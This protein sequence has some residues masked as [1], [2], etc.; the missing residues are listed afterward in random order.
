[1]ACG[2]PVIAARTGG[3]LD[4]VVDGVNGFYYDPARPEAI[5]LLVSRLRNDPELRANLAKGALHHAQKRSWR[6]TM[7]QL[8]E[9]YR[10]A[11]RVYRVNRYAGANAEQ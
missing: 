3:V 10:R 1:M 5:R 7:D 4:T 8:V 11:I 9:Y 6:D 2:L